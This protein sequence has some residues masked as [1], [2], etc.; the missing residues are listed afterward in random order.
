M[1]FESLVVRDLGVYADY[2]GGY[3]SHY[4]DKTGLEAD[5]IIHLNDGRWAAVEVKLGSAELDKAAK[6][7]LNYPVE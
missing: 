1:L 3:I 6:T 5:A 4:R 2:L 7:L